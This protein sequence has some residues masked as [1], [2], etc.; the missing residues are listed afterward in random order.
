MVLSKKYQRTLEKNIAFI[1]LE[2]STALH[3]G[4]LSETGWWLAVKKH[5]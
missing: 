4:A 5:T 1:Y 3:W 2:N